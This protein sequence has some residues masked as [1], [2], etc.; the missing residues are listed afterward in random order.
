MK[1]I[2]LM[3]HL[4]DQV[5]DKMEYTLN[6]LKGRVPQPQ[7]VPHGDSHVY[8]YVEKSLPQALVQ[9][10]V[11]LVSGLHAARLLMEHGFVQEQ[12][13][14][15]RTLDEIQEDIN[16]LSFSVIFN[17]L[18][19]LHLGYLEVFY[20]EE[21]DAVSARPVKQK[22][23]PISRKKIRDYVFGKQ[24]TLIDSTRASENFRTIRQIYS[25]YV[26]AASPQIMDMYGGNSP[27]FYVRGMV[28]TARQQ[29]YRNDLWNYFYR[30]ILCF[31]CSAKAF[32]DGNLFDQIHQFSKDFAK[33]SGM[34][35]SKPPAPLD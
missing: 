18:T 22:R 11:R 26:H 25:G 5:L 20:E 2:N 30:G 32:G 6:I 17:D 9:K 29:A 8:R 34:D 28:G 3:D 27:R 23:P 10:L 15:Q 24:T 19:S 1:D 4:F 7:R 14:L 13:V 33:Q 16:F 12:G 21:F 35:F 31:A